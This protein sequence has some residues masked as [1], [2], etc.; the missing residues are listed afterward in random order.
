[1]LKAIYFPHKNSKMKKKN[2][3]DQ[4]NLLCISRFAGLLY[5]QK[6]NKLMAKANNV[7]A[8]DSSI[9]CPQEN[10]EEEFMD[11]FLSRSFVV[12]SICREPVDHPH[13]ILL[14]YPGTVLRP[15]LFC[16]LFA[17][18]L[19]AAFVEIKGDCILRY[20]TVFISSRVLIVGYNALLIYDK[21][22]MTM[23]SN[24]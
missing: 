15:P 13:I 17:E 10:Q 20:I 9:K 23:V 22:K 1:M 24:L 7:G 8:S 2:D 16:L 12:P 14:V 19:P 11:I 21:G 18:S 6:P 4:L 5:G 3:N